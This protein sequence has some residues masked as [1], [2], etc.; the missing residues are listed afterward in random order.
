M[1]LE[2]LEY[3]KPELAQR[4]AAWRA[5]AAVINRSIKFQTENGMTSEWLPR[6]KM[7]PQEE[8]EMRLSITPFFGSTPEVL[9]SR[10]GALFKSPIEFAGAGEF[11]EQA[12]LDARTLS[13]FAVEVAACAQIYG[14]CAALIDNA[15]PRE[16]EDVEALSEAAA[17]EARIGRPYVTLY[18]A[19]QILDWDHDHQG[20]LAFVKLVETILIRETWD[21]KP[22]PTK[23]YIIAESNTITRY[24]VKYH[25]NQEP[26]ISAPEVINHNR[27]AVPVVFFA[28]FK[29]TDGIGSSI[30]QKNVEADLAATRLLSDLLWTLFLVGNPL[31]TLTTNRNEEEL[32]PFQT[33]PSRYIPLRAGKDGV[34]PAEKLEFVQLDP[35]GLEMLFKAHELAAKQAQDAASPDN[36]GAIPMQQSGVAL[37]WRFKTGEERIL[38]LIARAL[39]AFLNEILSKAGFDGATA[40]MPQNFD[41]TAEETPKNP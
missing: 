30:L 32:K 31:L 33:S 13:D 22:V 16:S 21:A 25:D 8:Y 18:T 12:T 6:G 41:M 3:K 26:E 7:E 5:A 20:Q 4:E 40:T 36:A 35:T 39:E 34:E 2:T 10:I 1:D 14:L 23:V 38:F 17:K 27:N 9:K 11:V 37:A 24:I 28:P 19:P 29:S 15:A